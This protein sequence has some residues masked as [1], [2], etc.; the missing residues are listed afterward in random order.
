M[1]ISLYVISKGEDSMWRGEGLYFGNSSKMD[2]LMVLPEIKT[3]VVVE[4]KRKRDRADAQ[5]ESPPSCFK[6]TIPS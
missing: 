4:N 1:L 2:P 6:N 5:I 3:E